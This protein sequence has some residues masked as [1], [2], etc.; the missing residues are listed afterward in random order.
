MGEAN[1][2]VK[3]EFIV[4]CGSII[5]DLVSL[6]FNYSLTCTLGGTPY[7]YHPIIS[8]PL[9]QEFAMD[10]VSLLEEHPSFH[11]KFAAFSVFSSKV[12]REQNL[13]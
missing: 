10:T 2:I 6:S 1:V 11:L 4:E 3:I 9:L 8:E 12:A 5:N 13:L 7:V